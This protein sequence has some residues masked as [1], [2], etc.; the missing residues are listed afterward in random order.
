MAALLGPAASR[1][2]EIDAVNCH[3][4]SRDFLLSIG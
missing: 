1:A 3:V 4:A 2:S